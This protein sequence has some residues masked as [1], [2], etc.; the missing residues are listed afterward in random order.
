M[1][2][3]IVTVRIKGV[4]CHCIRGRENI[5]VDTGY[6]GSLPALEEGMLE[7][8]IRLESIATIVLTH[9]HWDH[10]GSLREL[11]MRTR[12]QAVA[13]QKDVDQIQEGRNGPL[14]PY[15]IPGRAAKLLGR[16]QPMQPSEM[17]GVEYAIEGE[18][19]LEPFGVEGKI[20]ETPG[21]TAGSISLLLESGDLL[22]G[23]SLMGVLPWRKCHMPLFVDEPE[24]QLE[25]IL[26]IAS[27][28]FQRIH[29]GH[30]GMVSRQ[31]FY[32]FYERVKRR[33]L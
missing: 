26:K 16:K 8:G 6:P 13:H 1:Q 3:T 32:R 4:N 9:G 20:L 22:V 15:G 29:M 12:A 18:V 17:A 2:D 11:K 27:L 21:H 24:S 7:A 25:T 33:F 23:D 5:L 19:S 14:R 10:Y 31:E 30:G 28:D